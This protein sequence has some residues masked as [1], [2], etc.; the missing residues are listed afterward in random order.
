M[1]GEYIEKNNL[2]EELIEFEQTAMSIGCSVDY[3][4]GVTAVINR[5]K[6]KKPDVVVGLDVSRETIEK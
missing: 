6:N 2:I 3:S 4:E 1:K 5:I